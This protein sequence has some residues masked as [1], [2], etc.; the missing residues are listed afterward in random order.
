MTHGRK[1]KSTALFCIITSHGPVP[2]PYVKNR[3]R[4]WE[5][6]AG[7]SR[8]PLV[9]GLQDPWG[10]S[11]IAPRTSGP[12]PLG[13]E[14]HFCSLYFSALLQSMCL[15]TRHRAN[16]PTTAP[17]EQLD[18]QPLTHPSKGNTDH[19]LKEAS[20]PMLS[21]LWVGRAAQ[22]HPHQSSAPTAKVA[23]LHGGNF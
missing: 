23:T 22:P 13:G 14:V 17:T 4:K 20:W 12:S 18:R 6:G 8:T 5:P 10:P 1:R 9:P 16:V 21:G 11:L 15:T 19:V 2:G 3:G 7:D